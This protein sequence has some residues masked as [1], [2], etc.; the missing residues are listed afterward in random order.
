MTETPAATPPVV[1]SAFPFEIPHQTTLTTAEKALLTKPS[2][3]TTDPCPT[4]QP[5]TTAP[6][7]LQARPLLL[8]RLAPFRNPKPSEAN[9]SAAEMAEGKQTAGGS[10]KGEAQPSQ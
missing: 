8:I 5:T 2:Q 10:P 6:T 4:R 7:P 3:S 1:Q 9:R